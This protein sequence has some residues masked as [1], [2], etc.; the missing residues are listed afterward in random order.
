MAQPI[1]K[2]CACV[3]CAPRVCTLVPFIG[4]AINEAHIVEKWSRVNLS[5]EFWKCLGPQGRF[6]I[7][8]LYV[9]DI[10]TI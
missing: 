8:E 1:N 2:W 7:M 10:H 4:L 9:Q 6:G 3:Q 5:A